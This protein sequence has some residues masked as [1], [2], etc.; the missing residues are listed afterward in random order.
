MITGLVKEIKNYARFSLFIHPSPI[1][2]GWSWEYSN[3]FNL[4]LWNVLING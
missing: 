1:Y 4:I 3:C 2:T